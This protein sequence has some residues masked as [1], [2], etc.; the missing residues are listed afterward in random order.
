MPA[1]PMPPPRIYEVDRAKARV[2]GMVIDHD[3]FAGPG[4]SLQLAETIGRGDVEGD[5]HIG[6]GWELVG[7]YEQRE[8]E[9]PVAVTHHER[10][11]KRDAESSPALRAAATNPRAEP[12]ASPS[13]FMWQVT[14]TMDARA[15][16]SAALPT[17]SAVIIV[18]LLE[19]AQ[20]G[21]EPSPLVGAVVEPEGDVG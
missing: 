17:S 19:P 9:K 2:R 21:R 20:D 6:L 7:R 5:H 18:A 16:T 12:R 13:G 10:G 8:R 15:I 1:G 4:R 14:A 11:A 3:H